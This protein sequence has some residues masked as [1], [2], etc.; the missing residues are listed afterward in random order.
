MTAD[1][2]SAPLGQSKSRK[3][4]LRVPR[5][6]APAI[7][8][9]LTLMLLVFAGWVLLVD[10]PFGGEPM[11]V[12]AAH[13]AAAPAQEKAPEKQAPRIP[14]PTAGTTV[15]IIDGMSGKRQ[16]VTIGAGRKQADAL[17]GPEPR[18]CPNG[19]SSRGLRR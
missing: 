5:V 6:L 16:D 2:L 3:S 11:A 9:I 7:A 14:E 17:P 12:V 18:K 1:D 8:G 13:M 15:T 19:S 4:R 10:D